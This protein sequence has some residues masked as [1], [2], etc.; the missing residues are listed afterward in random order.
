MQQTGSLDRLSAGNAGVYS[1]IEIF[2][3]H[4]PVIAPSSMDIE[5][6]QPLG[7]GS[8]KGLDFNIKAQPQIELDTTANYGLAVNSNPFPITDPTGQHSYVQM[9]VSQLLQPV[10]ISRPPPGYALV[11]LPILKAQG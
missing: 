11:L 4:D 6:D 8:T 5:S 2:S 1:N 7:I 10:A 3:T 9:P